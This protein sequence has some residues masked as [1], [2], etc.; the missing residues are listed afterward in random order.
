[1]MYTLYL[2]KLN[3]RITESEY[4]RYYESFKRQGVEVADRL[5]R[6]QDAEDNYYITAKQIFKLVNRAYELFESSE[7]D[8]RRQ[9]IKLILSNVMV[10]DEKVLYDAQKP[11]DLI[12][13]AN[14]CKSWRG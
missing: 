4:D 3:G 13:E 7:V 9:L 14:H 11:F 5:E 6:L 2:D 10:E 1:M 12:L 8:E